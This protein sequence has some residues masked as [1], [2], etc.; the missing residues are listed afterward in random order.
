MQYSI[1]IYSLHAGGYI[2]KAL[3]LTIYR[4][5]AL[6]VKR[7]IRRSRPGRTKQPNEFLAIR[8]FI[9]VIKMKVRGV[10]LKPIVSQ[11][12]DLPQQRAQ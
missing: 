3:S 11:L 9:E 1:F 10:E 4:H 2:G 12:Q 5:H 8:L 7:Q 6:A